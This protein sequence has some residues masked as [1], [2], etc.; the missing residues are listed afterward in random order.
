MI[1]KIKMGADFSKAL[2]YNLDKVAS[3][4]AYFLKAYG[5][6][7]NDPPP[8]IIRKEFEELAKVCPM[9]E[10]V[11]HISLNFSPE[12]IISDNLM[13]TLAREYLNEMGYGSTPY[14]VYRHNDA[15]HPHIHIVTANITVGDDGKLRTLKNSNNFYHSNAVAAKLENKYNLVQAVKKER[16]R[17]NTERAIHPVPHIYGEVPTYEYLKEVTEYILT[18]KLVTN[19]YELNNLL[20]PY[21]MK[22]YINQARNGE[23][24]YKFTFVDP[25]NRKSMGV[26]GTLRQ[27]KLNNNYG[28][29]EQYFIASRKKL[30][31]LIRMAKQHTK[32]YLQKYYS[33]SGVDLRHKLDKLDIDFSNGELSYMGHQLSFRQLGIPDNFIKSATVKKEYYKAF[34][35][36]VTE[37]RKKCSIRNESTLLN[38]EEIKERMKAFVFNNMNLAKQQINILFEGYLEYKMKYLSGIMEKEHSKDI[39]W[40]NKVITYL[41]GLQLSDSDRLSLAE[42][43]GIVI[44]SE[45]IQIMGGFPADSHFA[46]TQETESFQPHKSNKKS[47]SGLIKNLNTQELE[48]IKGYISNIFRYFK[49]VNYQKLS[50]LLP[51]MTE[52]SMSAAINAYRRKIINKHLTSIFPDQKDLAPTQLL[53]WNDDE[54]EEEEDDIENQK[55]A[56]RNLGR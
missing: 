34:I 25:E 41:N 27:L 53:R 24:Y 50:P 39:K 18:N 42:K 5:F 45:K 55:R 40:I 14:V 38:S 9:K 7:V 13:L 28:T 44:S 26:S 3:E 48:V 31:D 6:S 22:V 21:S 52:E 47:Y 2:G 29:L 54:E 20:K 12:E 46:T 19:T 15:A 4:K 56:G 8:N 35:F 17:R 30:N 51:N 10:P 23:R 16:K 37:F 1:P 36:A 32:E 33:L 11:A 43:L 49:D